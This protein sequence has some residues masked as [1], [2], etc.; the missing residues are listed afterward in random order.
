MSRLAQGSL[1]NDKDYESLVLMRM[2][3]AAERQKLTEQMQKEDEED[4]ELERFYFS[5]HGLHP[6]VSPSIYPNRCLFLI[7]VTMVAGACTPWSLG[8]SNVEGLESIKGKDTFVSIGFPGN[9]AES[10]K[11]PVSAKNLSGT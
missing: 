3:Q 7:S 2:R 9:E 10:G 4:A 6:S 1:I 11:S 5:R 8:I